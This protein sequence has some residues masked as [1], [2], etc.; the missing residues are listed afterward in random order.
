[1][2]PLAVDRGRK[3][4][5]GIRAGALVAC[6]VM[7]WSGACA[8]DAALG[9]TATPAQA[10]AKAARDVR[11]VIVHTPGPNRTAGAP[12]FGQP[13]LQAH[14]HHYRKLAEA[15]SSRVRS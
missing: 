11:L 13:G 5:T 10:P 3:M 9:A 6:G 2:E 7:V 8:A 1:V 4:R 15:G 14:V 12:T